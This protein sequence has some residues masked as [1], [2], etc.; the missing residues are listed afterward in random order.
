[1]LLTLDKSGKRLLDC[2]QHSSSIDLP[3]E[4]RLSVFKTDIH[5]VNWV[6]LV[7]ITLSQLVTGAEKQKVVH[8]HINQK[9]FR[10]WLRQCA[11][12]EQRELMGFLLEFLLITAVAKF[13]RQG[14]AET[15]QVKSAIRHQPELCLASLGNRQDTY[16]KGYSRWLTSSSHSLSN[17]WCAPPPCEIHAITRSL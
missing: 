6:N 3:C 17:M 8:T 1:V 14:A 9:Q 2:P 16:S 15:I 13:V 12:I 11:V 5:V 7:V 10:A 4:F